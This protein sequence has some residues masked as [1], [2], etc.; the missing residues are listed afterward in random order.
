MEILLGIVRFIGVIFLVLLIFNLMIVVHEW[1]HFL[2]GR[3]RGLVID[4]FQIWFGKPIWKKTYNGVQYG[5][6][7]IPAGGFVS[8]PQMAPMEA[9]EGSA[10]DDVK[11]EPLPPISPLD[12]I[13]VAFAGPLFS[14][15]LAVAF[16]V[17]VWIVGQPED[18]A[19]ATTVIGSVAKTMEV[20][21]KEIEGPAWKAGIRPGDDVQYINGH[22]VNKFLGMNDSINWLVV[23]AESDDIEVRVLRDGKE[24]TFV[25]HAPLPEP[26]QVDG[27]LLQK[28]W[29]TLSSRR[30][31]RKIGIG[32]AT[33]PVVAG[34]LAN[35]PAA[36][37]D[38]K[39]GDIVTAIDGKP[40][41]TLNEIFDIEFVADKPVEF[42]VERGKKTHTV[43]LT[44]RLPD[45][46][47][48]YEEAL[49]GII[50]NSAGEQKII[51][52]SPFTLVGDSFRTIVN[53]LQKVVSPKSAIGADQLSGPVGIMSLYYR[54]FQ[55]PD[56][57]R[58][59]LWFSI[60]LN[61]N[62]AILNLMPFPVLDG[63]HIVMST[64][65]AIRRKPLNFKMLEIVQTAFVI[66]LLGFMAF[67]TFKDVGDHVPNG[68]QGESKE[69]VFL[70][71]G[72]NS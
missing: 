50:Y 7:T 16:A 34:S 63:G 31:L 38:L 36:D 51:H 19:S 60:V 20:G 33:T 67:V 44:P 30:Q 55:H 5:L 10:S 18:Q 27:N 46:P 15:L 14:F 37:V 70:P 54:L 8:L 53:T 12:K 65:E 61:V 32:P 64:L 6:G 42:T 40:V 49:T 58:L 22:R 68:S 56:G 21:G 17:V 13:I 25:A 41:T 9:I 39:E 28:G 52:V 43:T 3:W 62:L 66:L 35:S 59:V 1:G 57:W 24:M 4:R 29:N 69:P 45:Q 23:S 2:A 11:K 48:D 47:N 26:E 72:G 71:P